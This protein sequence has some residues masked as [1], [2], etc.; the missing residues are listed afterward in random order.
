MLA[1]RVCERGHSAP[2]KGR[3]SCACCSLS[4]NYDGAEQM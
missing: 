3:A 2:E 4:K 1:V